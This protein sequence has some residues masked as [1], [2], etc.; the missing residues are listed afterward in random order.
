[1]HDG[2]SGHFLSGKQIADKVRMMGFD[3]DPV[4]S[5]LEL[6]CENCTRPFIMKTMISQC[7]QCKMVY[8]VTP[9]HAH[10]PQSA[11]AAGIDY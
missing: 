6:T 9:C 10:M 1:M 4:P 2:C 11:R 3:K 5:P 8:A 7:T